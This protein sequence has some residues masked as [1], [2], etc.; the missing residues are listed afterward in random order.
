M[1]S[2][3]PR[4]ANIS[5]AVLA[6]IVVVAG[7][8][9]VQLGPRAGPAVVVV[10]PSP[11]V[12]D[13][14]PAPPGV[15]L[16][17]V[18]DPNHVGWLIGFD[19]TGKP[20][21]TAKISQLVGQSD[22]LSQAPDG[23]A[24]AYE[25]NAKGGFQLFF[26]RIGSPIA[27]SG[28]SVRYQSEMWADDSR[29]VCTMSGLGGHW[30]LGLMLPGAQNP[31]NVVAI[32]PALGGGGIIAYS[33]AACSARNDRAVVEYA[34]AGRPTAYWIIRISDGAILQQRLYAAG[35]VANV[36]ASM[37]ANLIAE[38]S[39]EST[40]QSATA[41]T[42]TVIR[43]ASDMSVITTLDPNVGILAFS[44]DNS[45]ELVSTA[46]LVAGQPAM[47]EVVDLQ[48]GRVMWRGE[49]TSPMSTFLVQPAAT[50]FAI[51]LADGNQP[52]T[53]LIISGDGSKPAKL[54]RLL[55]PIW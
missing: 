52:A 19:W 49:G 2:N 33:L 15:P 35:Q 25:P 10:S 36:T 29:H 5:F 39:A 42:Q 1:D 28:P 34:Y 55:V 44:G 8:M 17:W 3:S 7:F 32:D 47:L 16:L 4:R 41:V 43:R 54:P 6:G 18:Q 27:N 37:D 23:S 31:L 22:R 9:A 24:F 53:V 20:R 12:A 51:A 50:A 13:Y 26:D 11:V 46:P 21:G 45:S 38:N 30:S 14:G 40:G 48:A